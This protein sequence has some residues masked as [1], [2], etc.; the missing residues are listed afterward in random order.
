MLVGV[1][2]IYAVIS[3]KNYDLWNENQVITMYGIKNAKSVAMTLVKALCLN[4]E[5][6][7]VGSAETMLNEIT[8]TEP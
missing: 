6:K 1:S 7:I 8:V 2:C 5:T 4:M 3:C